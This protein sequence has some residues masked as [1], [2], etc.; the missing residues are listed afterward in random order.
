MGFGFVT[1]S[2]SD[3]STQFCG[4]LIAPL[5]FYPRF[6]YV[7]THSCGFSKKKREELIIDTSFTPSDIVLIRNKTYFI[8]IWIIQ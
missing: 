6:P 7:I 2:I 5:S 8:K 1:C 3:F 4:S